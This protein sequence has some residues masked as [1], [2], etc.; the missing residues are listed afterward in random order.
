M[1]VLVAVSDRLFGQ[2]VGDFVAKHRWDA[3][4]EIRLMHVVQ[5]DPEYLTPGPYYAE[6]TPEQR[7][8]LDD[9]ANKLMADIKHQI[10][11][12]QTDS[13]VVVTTELRV[14]SPKEEILTDAAS[15]PADLLVLG[16]HGRTGISKFM[17]GSTSTAVMTHALCSVVVIRRP[18][19]L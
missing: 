16:S 14:G 15:W 6:L 10:E 2:L 19:K 13:G 8:G 12:L 18:H 1:K 3:G 5:Y 11:S 9:S 4:T 7:K 17:L